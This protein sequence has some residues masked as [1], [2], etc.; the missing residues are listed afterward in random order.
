VQPEKVP[1]EPVAELHVTVEALPLY[2]GAHVTVRVAPPM[3]APAAK[4]YPSAEG[5]GQPPQG[6][7]SDTVPEKPAL[8]MD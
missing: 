8:V 6:F 1:H 7:T 4:M 3:R 2:P 5:S